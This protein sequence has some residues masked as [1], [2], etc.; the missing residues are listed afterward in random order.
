MIFNLPV[1][2]KSTLS[3][4]STLKKPFISLI[5]AGVLITSCV[6][7][8]DLDGDNK[9]SSDIKSVTPVTSITS[10][11]LTV[12]VNAANSTADADAEL[13][14]IW[15]FSD[16][17]VIQEPIAAHTFTQ[18]GDHSAELTI[19]NQK[20]GSVYQAPQTFNLSGNANSEAQ[21]T[22]VEGEQ[23]FKE[24]NCNLCH[25][26]DGQSGGTPLNLANYNH[27][28]LSQPIETAMPKTIGK[29]EDCQKQCADA[30]ATW[31]LS[32]YEAPTEITVVTSNSSEG[33]TAAVNASKTTAPN[34]SNLSFSWKFSD[35]TVINE[36]IA[37]HTF[38]QAGTH[39]AVLTITDLDDNA[40][41]TATQTFNLSGNVLTQM[42][43]TIV[44]GGLMFEQAQCLLCH[45]DDGQSGDTPLNLANYNHQTL[46]QPIETAMPKPIGKPEDC[47]K[48]CADAIA[49]WLLS[50]YE[51]PTEITVVTSNSSEGL[52]AAV[53]ASKTTAPNTNNL[54]Y[55]W[56]FSDNTVINEP[57]AA[58][59][60]AQAGTHTATVTVTDLTDNSI[61][62]KTET[63]VLSGTVLTDEDSTLVEGSL[64][65]EE[66]L[67][68]KCHGDNGTAENQPI[69]IEN[70]SHSS[71]ST[72]IETT[73]PQTFGEIEDCQKEC[74]DSIATWLLSFH[75]EMSCSD[76][77]PEIL[78][79]RL[80]K[81][82]NS[83]YVL[84]VQDLLNRQDIESQ[85]G[86]LQADSVV[87]GYKNN[88]VS[89]SISVSSLNSYWDTAKS[90]AESTSVSGLLNCSSN[91]VSSC[92]DQ[93]VPEFGLKAFR[94]PLTS[95]EQTAYKNLFK[96]GS[97][98]TQGAQFVIQAL[99]SSGNFI[100]RYEIGQNGQL[101]PYETA[102]MMSYTFWG[103][104]PDAVLLQ[105]A[106]NNTL[107]TQAQLEQEAQRLLASPKAKAQLARFAQQWLNINSI[108]DYKDASGYSSVYS[109]ALGA[110]MDTEFE[111]FTG[112]ALTSNEVGVEYLFN[113]DTTF[114]NSILGNFYGFTNVPNSGF[115]EV[116]VNEQRGGILNM[117]AVLAHY[118]KPNSSNPIARGVMVRERLLCQEFGT[119]PNNVGEVDPVS[120]DLSTRDRFA[121]HST[122]VTCA[123]C[124]V[125]IDDVGFAF[126]RY[127]GIGQYRTTEGQGIA[128]S[129]AGILIGLEN[130]SDEDVHNFNGTSGLNEILTTDGLASVEHCITEQFQNYMHG[131]AAY[132][133]CASED[134]LARWNTSDGI[135]GLWVKS[136]STSNFLN[137]Q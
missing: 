30:I 100:Y 24:A 93:F 128:V 51:A 124:H 120:P 73:M 87:N 122:N 49:T 44:E 72:R 74:A 52:T 95:S 123:F 65:Y 133:T 18:P 41:Y 2:L 59:T 111:L 42:D 22:I 34:G 50:L 29:P 27:Q 39:N 70:F 11:G 36:P 114:V 37:A 9:K 62:T 67:C 32:L 78:P 104:M 85:I 54:T 129:D 92:A 25:G 46:S 7:A 108:E 33:L 107:S 99:L 77:S 83:E 96:E 106:A 137:R 116:N 19:I 28:T 75:V 134:I 15:K 71:L 56:A 118:G 14:Y 86:L 121:A 105:K 45:G 84:T 4:Y 103:T 20:D 47:Q 35:N 26:D 81:L 109:T 64:L 21:N 117:G 94:R 90:I 69:L 125:K 101:T 5:A 1:S 135:V 115:N 82:T 53:N 110:A 79:K 91:D 3:F 102:S 60:F 97:S 63:F 8:A 66:A 131:V 136:V 10:V 57:I 23:L 13:I 6:P 76:Q 130:M 68:S 113:A 58:H 112:E 48:Q 55:S 80:R 38:A 127:D 31:L 43:N 98:T 89:G 88:A 119:P 12:T 40:T 61:Y 16:G 17:T 126:E 132:D